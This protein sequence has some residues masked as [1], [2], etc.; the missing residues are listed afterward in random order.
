MI[1]S[2]LYDFFLIELY[3]F[4]IIPRFVIHSGSALTDTYSQKVAGR[5]LRNYLALTGPIV[6]TMC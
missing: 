6:Q 1:L 3:N 2:N 4:E 5:T